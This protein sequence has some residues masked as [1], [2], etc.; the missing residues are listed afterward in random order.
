MAKEIEI[1][2]SGSGGQGLILAARILS[3]AL[4]ANGLS[5][6]QSQSYEPTSRGGLSRSDLVISDDEVDY[7]LVTALDYLVIMDQ[8]AAHASARLLKADAVVIIDSSRVTSPPQGA[9]KAVSFPMTEIA[10][11]LGSGRVANI[12]ALGALSG[13]GGPC[14]SESLEVAVG[15][16]APSSFRELNLK[17]F[18]EGYR[19]ASE[20]KAAVSPSVVSLA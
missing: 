12:V 6:A 19:L 11:R 20:D 16:H 17:A 14:T 8:I 13:V 7:P 2:L 1:R 4:T 10:R 15:D 9:F 5:V 18:K 3:A